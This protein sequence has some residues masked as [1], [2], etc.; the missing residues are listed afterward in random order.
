MRYMANKKVVNA[1]PEEK[2]GIQFK[3]KLEG[4]MYGYLIDA[5]I[6]PDYEKYT[7]TLSPSMKTKVPFYN[8]TPKRGFHQM[9]SHVAPITYTPDFTYDCNGL[10]VIIEA[11]GKENDIFP[12]KKNMFRK[13]L[14]TMDFPVIFFEVRNKKELLESLEIAKKYS[15]TLRKSRKNYVNGIPRFKRNKLG[16]R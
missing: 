2:Y 5:G 10:F 13:L 1:T 8:R 9:G 7:Y 15:S 3:S 4:K 16:R 12:L 11:K 6:T 14:E